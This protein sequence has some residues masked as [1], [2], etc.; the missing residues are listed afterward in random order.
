MPPSAIRGL[1][2]STRRCQTTHDQARPLSTG[3]GLIRLILCL[4]VLVNFFLVTTLVTSLVTSLVNCLIS[5]QLNYN[6]EFIYT[7]PGS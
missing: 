7:K 4:L 6:K 5:I 3:S 2:P 1:P